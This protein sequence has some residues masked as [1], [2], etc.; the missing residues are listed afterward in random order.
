MFPI[1]E[2]PSAVSGLF[3]QYRG[4]FC[5]AEGFEWV[6]RYVTGL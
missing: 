2:I 1:I 5:R 3:N 4:I 6:S